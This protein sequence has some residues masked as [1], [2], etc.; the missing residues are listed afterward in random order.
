M[1]L[2]TLG[3]PAPATRNASCACGS[4]RRYKA[5]H[6]RLAVSRGMTDASFARTMLAS[7]E[8]HRAGRLDEARAGYERVLMHRPD[9]PDAL[10]MLGVIDL[11]QGDL[12]SALR[13]LR[14][15]TVVFGG[16]QS[17]AVHN[18]ACAL[19]AR[20]VRDETEHSIRL[21]LDARAAASTPPG[22]QVAHARVSVVVPS[23]N[24]AAYVGDA[25]T[26]AIEQDRPPVE[27]V[28]VDDGSSDDSVERIRA[29][30]RRHPGR[31][32]LVVRAECRGA[33][34]TI[35]EAVALTSGDWINILNSDDRFAPDRLGRMSDA[36]AGRRDGWGFSR[37]RFID[38]D[39]NGSKARRGSTS[40]RIA[41]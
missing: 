22:T 19:A 5:C 15:A 27:I 8:S 17:D 41:R 29:S 40:R 9:T 38:E 39:A 7:L 14:R 32:R 10:N 16:A 20:L 11:A 21:W 34:A 18:L 35:N 23:H 28:V 26:S 25:L 33:A 36:I 31:I 1:T 24:H 6:G 37:C 13:R 12:A 4:G 2:A 3:E 30:M